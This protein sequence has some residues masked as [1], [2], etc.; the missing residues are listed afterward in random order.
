MSLFAA[1]LDQQ[2]AEAAIVEQRLDDDDAGQQP[3]ELQHDDGE[4]RDQRVPERVAQHDHRGSSRPSAGRCGCTAGSS[5]R[6]SRR[7]SSGRCSPCRRWRWSAPAGRSCRAW[8]VL[9]RLGGRAG[10][11]LQPDHLAG[12]DH[13]QHHARDI[14]RRRGGGDGDGRRA[15]GPA[16]TP[17]ACRR[18]RR[19]GARPGT[20][21]TITQNISIAVSHSRGQSTSATGALNRVEWPEVA[22][23][24]AAEPLA[25]AHQRTAG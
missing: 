15:P 21:T 14:L 23:H 18:G 3:R 22:A 19:A 8:P 7:G 5:P 12:E 9:G 10:K 17:R 11:P 2:P 13:R 1:A 16:P 6:P 25:V 24:H 20:I 4:G